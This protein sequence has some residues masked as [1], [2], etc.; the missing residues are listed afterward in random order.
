MWTPSQRNELIGSSLL[1][2]VS[3]DIIDTNRY[4]LYLVIEPSS[5]ADEGIK[6]ESD[7]NHLSSHC[8][9]RANHREERGFEKNPQG[10]QY[11][12]VT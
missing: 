1:E 2:I 5:K 3:T 7:T 12:A 8:H 6:F 9:S 11:L 10:R 4:N